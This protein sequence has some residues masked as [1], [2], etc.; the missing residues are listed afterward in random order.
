MID[1]QELSP[2]RQVLLQQLLLVRDGFSVLDQWGYNTAVDPND[3]TSGT[4]RVTL[5][6]VFRP[7]NQG[8]ANAVG[9][10]AIDFARNHDLSGIPK[11]VV[12]LGSVTVTDKCIEDRF[13]RE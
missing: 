12:Y 8:P 4:R 3:P 1:V 2:D 13:W 5:F 6:E 11:P 9:S 7:I 10:A